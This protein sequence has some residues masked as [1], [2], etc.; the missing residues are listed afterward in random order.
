MSNQTGHIEG[1]S[2]LKAIC[3]VLIV[4]HHA[5][6]PMQNRGW[7]YCFLDCPLLWPMLFSSLSPVFFCS[8]AVMLQ[9]VL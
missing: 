6:L 4:F 9:V 2:E 7:G 1:L 8:E 5:L 3:I